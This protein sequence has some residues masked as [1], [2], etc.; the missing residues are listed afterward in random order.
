M[1]AFGM[2][3]KTNDDPRKL[4]VL[5]AR[6]TDLAREHSLPSVLVG[7]AAQEGDLRFP[8]FIDFV[9]SALR[10][11]DGIFRMTRERAVL[12][13][14]DVDVQRAHEILDRLLADFSAQ[15]PAVERAPFELRFFDL[16]PGVEEPSVKNVLMAIFSPETNPRLH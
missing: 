11:E 10:V 14:A 6:A 8:G 1:A 13:L 3:S 7:L 15:V 2:P 9:E 12:H 16:R 4:R 5:L